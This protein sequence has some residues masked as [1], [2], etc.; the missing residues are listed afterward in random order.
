[1]DETENLIEKFR[2]RRK[3]YDDE[4]EQ[5]EKDAKELEEKTISSMTEALDKIMET[6]NEIIPYFLPD[7][8]IMLYNAGSGYKFLGTPK[9]TW[10]EVGIDSTGLYFKERHNAKKEKI[11][12]GDQEYLVNIESSEA[13]KESFEN[14]GDEIEQVTLYEKLIHDDTRVADLNTGNDMLRQYRF[15]IGELVA[16][17][18]IESEEEF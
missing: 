12:R 6:A 13:R 8:V 10:F 4:I 5:E 2:I 7:D 1:M 17:V 11:V 3:E 9:T 18:N 14:P 15:K 16:D